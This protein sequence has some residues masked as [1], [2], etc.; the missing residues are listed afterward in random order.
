[1]GAAAQTYFRTPV[2][3][4]SLSQAAL[5]ASVIP[6]PSRYSPRVNAELADQ[7]RVRVLD[8]MLA[9]GKITKAVH[10]D[11]VAHHVWLAIF[12]D[13]PGPATIVYPPQTA[14][15]VQP[16]FT[17]YVKEE[18]EK[19]LPGCVPGDCP[20]LD[21]GGL[22]V[23]TT[24]DQ[25]VQKAAEEEV[26]KS[27]GDND[28]TLQMS[29]V[30]V[31]P[32]T[33]YVRAIV[34]GRDFAT[35][36]YNTV[37]RDPG[38]QPGSS[39]KPFILATAFEQGIQPT[40]YYSGATL[41]LPDGTSIH[42]YGGESYGTIDLRTATVHSVNAVYARLVLD[43]GAD[44]VCTSRPTTPRG[45]APAWRSARWRPSPSR[46]RRRIAFSPTTAGGRPRPRSSR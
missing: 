42:N 5:L 7:R 21:K 1:V 30:A 4:L 37:I 9:D 15:S 41:T 27:M 24:L 3:Q 36:Q 45:T 44:S 12:G 19:T 29:L 28:P 31:E 33:G 38:R 8:E 25:K 10:D 22:T 39:F 17:Q 34:G 14:Q 6:A 13:A 32:P 2:S 35:S 23:V 26:A 40:K 43:V 16:W 18:L 11:T 20:L 46:W